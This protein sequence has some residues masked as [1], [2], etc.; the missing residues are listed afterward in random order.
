[1][2]RTGTTREPAER[3]KVGFFVCE[4]GLYIYPAMTMPTSKIDEAATIS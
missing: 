1:M 2:D 4:Y 3:Y